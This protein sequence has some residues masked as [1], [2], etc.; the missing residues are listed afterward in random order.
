MLTTT[1]MNTLQVFLNVYDDTRRRTE[2][3]EG[4]IPDVIQSHRLHGR[5]GVERIA[6]QRRR[7]SLRQLQRL[8]LDRDAHDEEEQEHEGGDNG[9]EDVEYEDDAFDLGV[10]D[11]W[12]RRR[13]E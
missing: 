9:L 7:L 4:E 13:G 10:H 6:L 5:R 8:V 11:L 1:Y 3:R 12:H 2:D